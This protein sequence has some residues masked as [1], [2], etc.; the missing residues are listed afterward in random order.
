MQAVG[1]YDSDTETHTFLFLKEGSYK[2]A[3][4]EHVLNVHRLITID[5]LGWLQYLVITIFFV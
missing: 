5:I 3:L 4:A 1:R 2:D